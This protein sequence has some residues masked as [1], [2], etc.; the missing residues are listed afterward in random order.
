MRKRLTLIRHASTFENEGQ[1]PTPESA[2]NCGLSET[3]RRQAAKLKGSFDLVVIS[4]LRRALE[5]YAVSKI[6]CRRVL[7]C[8]LVREQRDD[9]K[10]FYCFLENEEPMAE[11]DAMLRDRAQ[12]AKKY[13]LSLNSSDIGIVSHGGFI[14]YLLEAFDQPPGALLKNTEQVTFDV[15]QA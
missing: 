9:L 1:C 7:I 15:T 3:G 12:A 10:D 8:D 2:L 4:P 5:T 11:T 13:L 6:R 14:R